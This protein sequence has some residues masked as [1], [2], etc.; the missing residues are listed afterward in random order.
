M[1]IDNKKIIAALQNYDFKDFEDCLQV[2]CAKSVNADYIVTRDKNDFKLSEVKAID[3]F[4][5]FKI[6]NDG[7]DLNVD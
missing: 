7:D 5:L 2:E 4:E 1:T 3:P 6:F